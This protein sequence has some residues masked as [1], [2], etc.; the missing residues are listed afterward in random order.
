[1]AWPP[2][3]RTG[4][5]A[6]LLLL[7]A[8]GEDVGGVQ[9]GIGAQ[10][11]AVVL[12]GL[13]GEAPTSTDALLGTPLVINF[14][15]T[16]CVPCRDE[17]PSLERLSHRLA[18][19]GVRVIGVTVDDDRNLAA[20]FVRTHRLTF[21]I[22]ADADKKQFQSLLR[23]KSLPETVLVTAEGAIAARVVG[24]RDWNGAEGDRLLERALNLRLAPTQ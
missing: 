4:L 9:P 3:W 18:A 6:G 16:W 14:W 10:L 2:R 23:V 22:Y 15:A 1:M 17:M 24:A 8:C 21:R 7:A 5:L 11:P 20:E 12:T 19:H 13:I